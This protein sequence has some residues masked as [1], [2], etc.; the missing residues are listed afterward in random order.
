MRQN[1]YIYN[2]RR[3]TYPIVKENENAKKDITNK[4]LSCFDMENTF[5]NVHVY[6]YIF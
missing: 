3:Y 2:N 4:S 1:L 5:H 6:V